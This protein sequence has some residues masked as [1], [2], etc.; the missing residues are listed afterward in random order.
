GEA[1]ADPRAALACA[2]GATYISTART[3]LDRLPD[4][5]GRHDLVFEAVGVPEVAFGALPALAP[6]GIF[7]KSGVPARRGPV[8]ADL[9]RWMYDLV[10]NNQGIVGTV[11]AGRVPYEPAI[12]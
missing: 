7:I 10:L 2:I 5:V 1:E 3:P 11:N 4:C 9:S 6:N 12:P 8:A